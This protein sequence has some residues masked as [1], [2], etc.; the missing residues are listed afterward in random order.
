MQRR[1]HNQ[2]VRAISSTKEK[3][4]ATAGTIAHTLEVKGRGQETSMMS[5]AKDHARGIEIIET[6]GIETSMEGQALLEIMT[7]EVA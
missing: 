3:S 6:T 2:R 1:I 5:I 7:L 4:Q